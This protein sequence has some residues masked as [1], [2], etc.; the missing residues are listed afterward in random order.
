MYIVVIIEVL[1]VCVCYVYNMNK[2]KYIKR[3]YIHLYYINTNNSLIYMLNEFLTFYKGYLLQYI[4][5]VNR[6]VFDGNI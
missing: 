3:F 6:N 4:K 2:D 1:N 5:Y